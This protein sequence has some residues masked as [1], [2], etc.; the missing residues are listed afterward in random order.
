MG[1]AEDFAYYLQAKPG[2]FFT[3]GT[4]KVGKPLMTLHTSTYDYND[5]MLASGAYFFLRIV[6]DRLGLKLFD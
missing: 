1:V 3:L 2:C 5:D 6:E 4:M